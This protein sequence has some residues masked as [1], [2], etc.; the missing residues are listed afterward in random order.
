[1]AV[2]GAIAERTREVLPVTWDMLASLPTFGDGA[3]RRVVDE[4]KQAV[5]GENVEPADEDNYPLVVIRYVAKVAALQLISPGMDGWLNS[6]I[7]TSA[8]GTNENVVYEE[9]IVALQQLRKNLLEETRAEWPL[10]SDMID[11]VPLAKAPLIAINTMNDEFLTPSHQEFPRPY[12]ITDR[13]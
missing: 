9:R 3:L 8:T 5:L 13:T 1:M 12:R 2:T 7:S 11:F 6:P 10:V 4:T